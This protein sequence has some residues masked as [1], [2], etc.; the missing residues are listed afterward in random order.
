MV[1]V[2]GVRAVTKSTF[3]DEWLQ[4]LVAEKV[5]ELNMDAMKDFVTVE[6]KV[7]DVLQKN[8]L[9]LMEKLE[10]AKEAL[11]FYAYGQHI[12]SA[13]IESSYSIRIEDG[14]KAK[15]CLKDIEE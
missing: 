10:K 13:S 8:N 6:K 14:T 15:D 2:K 9:D 11:R 5:S 7:F 4:P 1:R 3:P 12:D